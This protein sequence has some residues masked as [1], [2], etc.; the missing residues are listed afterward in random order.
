MLSHI[1]DEILVTQ[2]CIITHSHFASTRATRP[3][4]ELLAL[5]R[6]YHLSSIALQIK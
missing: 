2:E 5:G 1:K 3:F 4:S 6:N